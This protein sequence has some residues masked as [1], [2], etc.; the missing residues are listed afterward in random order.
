MRISKP[1][2]SPSK[3]NKKMKK[4][5]TTSMEQSEETA[6]LPPPAQDPALGDKTPAYVEWYREAHT[7]K[8][9]TEKYR[10][11]KLPQSLAVALAEPIVS[12]R[13]PTNG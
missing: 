12:D 8:E 9:F 13:M 5:Q 7:P 11:R 2:K 3:Q 1:R 10:G 6:T 4:N